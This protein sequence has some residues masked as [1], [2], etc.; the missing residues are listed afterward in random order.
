MLRK[1]INNYIDEYQQSDWK[2]HT[3]YVGPILLNLSLLAVLIVVVGTARIYY[4]ISN[5]ELF[6]LVSINCVIIPIVMW[7]PIR[8]A[9]F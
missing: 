1:L 6:L 7:Y 4:E 2:F 3:R 9:G 5:F 8:K